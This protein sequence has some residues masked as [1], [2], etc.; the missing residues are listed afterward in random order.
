MDE[1]RNIALRFLDL[2][3]KLIDSGGHDAAIKKEMDKLYK[4]Y[5]VLNPS[6]RDIVKFALAQIKR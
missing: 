6:E 1:I 2:S 3:Q 5:L 4:Q